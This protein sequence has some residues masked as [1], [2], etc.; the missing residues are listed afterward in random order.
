[1]MDSVPVPTPGNQLFPKWNPTNISKHHLRNM[2]KA[3][4]KIHNNNRIQISFINLTNTFKDLQQKIFKVDLI[5]ENV[6][7]KTLNEFQ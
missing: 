1:M 7:T 6:K 5:Y 4:H 2:R 3:I